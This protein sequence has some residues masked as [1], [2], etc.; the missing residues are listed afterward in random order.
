MGE[1]LKLVVF[2]LNEQKYALRLAVVERV[3]RIVEIIRL[4]KAPEIIL[5]VINIQGRIIPVVNVCRRFG[6]PERDTDLNDQLIIANT[7]KRTVALVVDAVDG[8]MEFPDQKV[9]SPDQILPS[10]EYIAGVIKME[11]GLI[12]V[13]DIDR[14]LSLEEEQRLEDVLESKYIG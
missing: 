14:F 4:P 7:E 13:H 1:P 12:L 3:V 10:M 11:N 2:S 6:L 8:V 9:T 5:G